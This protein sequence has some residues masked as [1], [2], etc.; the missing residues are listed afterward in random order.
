VLELVGSSNGATVNSGE[1]LPT[2]TAVVTEN[3]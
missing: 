2:S 1:A 3:A